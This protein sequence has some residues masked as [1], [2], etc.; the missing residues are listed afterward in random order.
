M[1]NVPKKKALLA[2][3]MML[4]L[5]AAAFLIPVSAQESG[6]DDDRAGDKARDRAREKVRDEVRE[7]RPDHPGNMTAF[8]GIGAAVETDEN[9]MYRS[10]LRFGIAK[11]N[12][13]ET[14]YVVKRGLITINDEGSPVRYQAI[15]DTWTIE[16]REDKS[17]FAA[18]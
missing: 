9:T 14:D 2:G 8:L 5:L 11:A 7:H 10:H 1:T 18:E 3:T 13:A 15:P 4:S 17:G 12:D 6:E 16:V